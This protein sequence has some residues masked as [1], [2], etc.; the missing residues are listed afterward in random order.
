METR[1]QTCICILR[2]AGSLVVA[3]CCLSASTAVFAQAEQ[4]QERLRSV[5]AQYQAEKWPKGVL[6]DGFPLGSLELDGWQGG[7]LQSDS[8]HMKRKFTK[9]DATEKPAAIV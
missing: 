5:R 7:A 1:Q 9:A 8:G 3:A 4:A 6:R 2:P